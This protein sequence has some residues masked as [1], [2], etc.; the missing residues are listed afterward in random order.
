M[1][2]S[3]FAAANLDFMENNL[4][5]NE[6]PKSQPRFDQLPSSLQKRLCR[7]F[8]NLHGRHCDMGTEHLFVNLYS[9]R[10]NIDAMKAFLDLM[11][12][13]H[14]DMANKGNG[15]VPSVPQTMD[16]ATEKTCVY[17]T[18]AESIEGFEMMLCGRIS[19]VLVRIIREIISR[20]N[21]DANLPRRLFSASMSAFKTQTGDGESWIAPAPGATPRESTARSRS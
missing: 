2:D 12:S 3:P 13:S 19:L 21:G 8:E 7:V 14:P 15:V 11:Y 4:S 17:G 5:L 20:N 1:V 16:I 18:I 6:P 10:D 9:R